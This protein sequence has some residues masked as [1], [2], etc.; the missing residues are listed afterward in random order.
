MERR[1]MRK[2]R[3]GILVDAADIPMWAYTMLERIQAGNYASIELIVQNDLPE[4]EDSKSR[5][6]R[7][8]LL[9]R[10]VRK[11]LHSLQTRLMDHVECLPDAS[12]PR[13]FKAL[14][15]DVPVVEVSPIRKMLSDYFSDEDIHRI[16]AFDIDVLVRL[17]F[18]DPRGEILTLPKYGV[19]SY[20]HG[21]SRIIR[22]G[23]P[24]FWEAMQ[25]WPETGTVLQ[26]LNED[27]D[28]SRVLY[29]S[30]SCTANTSISENK[31]SIYWKSLSF[32]PRT[33]EELYLTGE[34][35][36][37]RKC[38]E[39]NAHPVLYFNRRF[40]NPTNAELAKLLLWKLIE[41]I[42]SRIHNTF[43]FDQ[44]IL[45]FDIRP[46]MSSTFW[47]FQKLIPPKPDFGR[48]PISFVGMG[49][50]LFTSRSTCTASAKGT[51]H[52]L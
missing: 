41:R 5:N 12:E 48:I 34:D 9:S 17:G 38:Q 1:R 42:G 36:F 39:E 13:E 47:R 8:D 30:W 37:F 25:G 11:V 51:F 7:R 50:T 4:A 16:K 45:M 40:A 10:I 52:S 20:H 46:G 27:P 2:I 32:L 3:I 19:W 18:R 6:N 43:Y 29:S 28:N 23:P 33:L 31:N 14:L 44:F 22:G 15:P 26:I 49:N 24:G 35:A 21:D